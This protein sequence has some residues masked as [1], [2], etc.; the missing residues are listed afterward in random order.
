M[1]L[2]QQPT[3]IQTLRE[4][5]LSYD[6]RFPLE[7]ALLTMACKPWRQVPH[8]TAELGAPAKPQAS[9]QWPKGTPAQS[10][11]A[12][13]NQE[14]L[15]MYFDSQ[16]PSCPHGRNGVQRFQVCLTCTWSSHQPPAPRYC[17]DLEA[18]CGCL[19]MLAAV[20]HSLALS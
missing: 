14:E 5:A 15:L 11:G 1:E 10:R 4:Q 16:L 18:A 6:L 13:D 20:S 17:K 9:C 12:F 8:V 19:R 7:A 3:G 2:I